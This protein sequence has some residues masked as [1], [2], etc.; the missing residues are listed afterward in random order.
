MPQYES[1]TFELAS[2]Y[3]PDDENQE[4]DPKTRGERRADAVK[5]MQQ[6]MHKQIRGHLHKSVE[7]VTMLAMQLRALGGSTADTDLGNAMREAAD[8]LEDI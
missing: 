6:A 4:P 8:F 2:T 1:F 7:Q 3:E 5:G